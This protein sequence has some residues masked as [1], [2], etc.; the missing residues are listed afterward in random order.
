MK[1]RPEAIEAAVI[2][3]WRHLKRDDP[4]WDFE[5]TA[6]KFPEGIEAHRK[7]VTAILETGCDLERA[8]PKATGGKH[9]VEDLWDSGKQW[10]RRLAD[11]LKKWAYE[12]GLA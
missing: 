3:S 5:L 1:L 8:I 9:S 4:V 11:F 2:D 7:M 12:H 6:R 10:N